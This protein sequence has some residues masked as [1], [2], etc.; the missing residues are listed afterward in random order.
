MYISTGHG[1]LG[2]N[3]FTYCNN[4]PTTY[5]DDNGK[6]MVSTMNGPPDSVLLDGGRSVSSSQVVSQSKTP[7]SSRG[8]K[9]E[10]KKAIWRD[11]Q[12]ILVI[13]G[14]GLSAVGLM[15]SVGIICIP[16]AANIIANVVG[17]AISIWSAGDWFDWW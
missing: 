12:D 15:S 3:M 14:V 1:L 6:M 4:I 9:E 11:A 16:K 2:Y 17:L 8:N 7:I 13:T 10:A 5:S